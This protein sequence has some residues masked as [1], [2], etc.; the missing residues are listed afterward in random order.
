MRK[1]ARRSNQCMVRPFLSSMVTVLSMS[2]LPLAAMASNMSNASANKLALQA[3]CSEAHNEAALLANGS[4]S[5]KEVIERASAR[6]MVKYPNVCPDV[7]EW[8][9]RIGKILD[10]YGDEPLP[11][12]CRENPE[13]ISME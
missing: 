8:A 1:S 10:Q 5:Y 11:E 6:A 13:A 4:T 7:S 2:V 9:L 12:L 3:Y